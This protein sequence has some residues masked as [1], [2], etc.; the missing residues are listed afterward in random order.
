MNILTSEKIK[1]NRC[2]Q[3]FVGKCFRVENFEQKECR[4]VCQPRVFKVKIQT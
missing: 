4:I 1:P 3:I 2:G